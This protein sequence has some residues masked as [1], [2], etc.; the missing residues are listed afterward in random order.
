[1]PKYTV[2]QSLPPYAKITR[3]DGDKKSLEI[4]RECVATESGRCQISDAKIEEGHIVYM[5]IDLAADNGK[6]MIMAGEVEN[7]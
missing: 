3:T 5:P 6:D 7:G 1:V 2:R 4:W